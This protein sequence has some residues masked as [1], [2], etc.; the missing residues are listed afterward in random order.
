ME[1]FAGLEDE[2]VTGREVEAGPKRDEVVFPDVAG[3]GGEAETAEG[4]GEA[5][6]EGQAHRGLGI[7]VASRLSSHD[8]R[9]AGA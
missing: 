2:P 6:N 7:V 8:D 9:W 3:Q 5:A 4:G 1:A